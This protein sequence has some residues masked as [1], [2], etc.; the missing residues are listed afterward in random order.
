MAEPL[1]GNQW[2]A[3]VAGLVSASLY[4]LGSQL[5]WRG[6]P[7][8]KHPA[9][10]GVYRLRGWIESPL[11]REML[12][13]ALAVGYPF[14]M[15]ARGV[16]AARDTGLQ[17]VDWSLVLPWTLGITALAVVWMAIFWGSYWAKCGHTRKALTSYEASINPARALSHTCCQEGYSA[18]WRATLMPAFGGYWGV[19]LGVVLK[20]LLMRTNPRIA[21]A[22]HQAGRR[23]LVVLD[24]ALD[25][26]AASLYVLSGSVVAVL[27]MRLVCYVSLRATRGLFQARHKSPGLS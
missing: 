4:F 24:W 21:E 6:A 12:S 17:P 9:G 27:I 7:W 26:L 20:I 16:F 22:L 18:T 23:E 10:G 15:V 14:F 5:V 8:L 11:V 1:A 25:W 2:T 13:L 3:L 19:W